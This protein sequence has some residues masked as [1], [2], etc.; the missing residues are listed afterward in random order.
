MKESNSLNY[1][2]SIHFVKNRLKMHKI[3]YTG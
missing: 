2:I 3:V 1:T